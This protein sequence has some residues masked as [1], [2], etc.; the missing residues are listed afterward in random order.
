[1]LL[2]LWLSFVRSMHLN[3][4]QVYK[5]I[6][7]DL[8]S[9]SESF[10]YIHT[11]SKEATELIVLV[12]C[13]SDVS[14]PH[15]MIG[16][17]SEV[18][19]KNCLK[20]DK[21][22]NHA[23]IRLSTSDLEVNQTYHLK[24]TCEIFCSY[25]IHLSLVQPI[26]LSNSVPILA[27]VEAEKSLIFAF[28]LTESSVDAFISARFSGDLEMLIYSNS[29]E[30]SALP[31]TSNRIDDLEFYQNDIS[32]VSKYI[33][34]LKGKKASRFTLLAKDNDTKSVSLIP[35]MVYTDTILRSGYSNFYVSIHSYVSKI[36]ISLTVFNGDADLYLS[37]STQPTNTSYDIISQSIGNDYIKLDRPS[38]AHYDFS[39]GRVYISVHGYTD[40][41]FSIVC[42][43][44]QTSSVPLFDGIPQQATILNSELLNFNY[45]VSSSTVDLS[46]YL[47]T[48]SG[49]ADIYVKFCYDRCHISIEDLELDSVFKSI[50]SSSLQLIDLK[51]EPEEICISTKMCNLAVAVFAETRSYFSLTAATLVSQIK[52]QQGLSFIMSSP[53]AGVRVYEY[54]VTNPS[55][56]EVDF[57]LSPIL[58]DPDICVRSQGYEEENCEMRSDK[59][60][61]EIDQVVFVKGEEKETLESL[62]LISVTC[63]SGCY[64]SIIARE[65]AVGK[66]NTLHLI[67]GHPQKDTLYNVTDKDYRLY[68]FCVDSVKSDLKIVLT[69]ITGKF[70][71]FVSNNPDNVDWKNEKFDY[72]WKATENDEN[73]EVLIIRKDDANYLADSNYL[74]LVQANK[75]TSDNSAT[76]SIQFARSDDIMMLTADANT[77]GQVQENSYAYYSFP[78]HYSHMDLK[79]SLMVSTGD[80]DLYISFDY[81]NSRPTKSLYSIR[82]SHFG[83]E[84]LTLLWDDEISKYCPDINKE[85]T[86][87][88]SHGCFI[89]I[90]VYSQY[91]SAFTLRVSPLSEVPKY[92]N[93]GGFVHS[94]LSSDE[95]DFYYLFIDVVDELIIILQ[96]A[97]GE[98]D[99]LVSLMEKKSAPDDIQEWERPTEDFAMIKV[100]NLLTEEVK[101]TS[102]QLQ[103]YCSQTCI[104]LISVKCASS[105]CVFLLENPEENLIKL[106]EGQAKYG[107]AGKETQFYSYVC[108]KEREEI[109]IILT[110]IENCNPSLYVAKGKNRRPGPED[111]D[112]SSE[113]S[114][115]DSV[116][117]TSNDS[118]FDRASMIGTYVIGVQ[119][120]SDLCSYTLTVT[121]HEYPVVILNPGLPQQGTSGGGL[122]S[123]YAL[124][125]SIAQKIKISVT[126][127]TGS[128]FIV[129]SI[130]K[131]TEDELYA[132]LPTYTY[133][134]WNSKFEED[135]YSITITSSDKD[136]C[137][138]CYYLIGIASDDY[139]SFTVIGNEEL[140]MKLLQNGVPY[141]SELEPGN[142][143]LFSFSVNV[144]K[145]FRVILA[146]YSGE[147]NFEVSLTR[148]MNEISWVPAV[149]LRTKSLEVLP[150]DDKFKI[151]TYYLRVT[152]SSKNALYSLVWY[153]QGAYISLI[154]GWSMIYSI[155]ATQKDPIKF[156]FDQTGSVFCSVESLFHQSNPSVSAYLNPK[157]STNKKAIGTFSSLNYTGNHLSLDFIVPS[158]DSLTLL[159]NDAEITFRES[160]EFSLYCT[161]SFH[162]AVLTPGKQSIG[163]LSSSIPALRYE[164]TLSKSQN[165]NIYVIPCE[166]SIRLQAST[167]WTII[168]GDQ[169]I[170]TAIKLTD[171][172]IVAQVM[173]V[174]GKVYLSVLRSPSASTATFKIY[175]DDKKLPRLYAGNQGFIS[176]A[177]NS[178][179]VKLEWSGVEYANGSIYDGQV[180]YYLFYTEDSTVMLQST[181]QAQYAA[182][183]SM[184]SWIGNTRDLKTEIVLKREGFVTIVAH[185]EQEGV[186]PLRDLIYDKIKITGTAERAKAGKLIFFLSLI[187]L[188]LFAGLGI[189]FWKFRK[190]KEE[191]KNF[192]DHGKKIALEENATG[193]VTINDV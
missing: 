186:S 44:D 155:K 117:I 78:V 26:S 13:I 70:S 106:N 43:L 63:F 146:E 156:K 24:V 168:K 116:K 30:N 133:F 184:G 169:H 162:P 4:G 187:V 2:Y 192:E 111:F 115:G 9:T 37:F 64:Y 161:A 147:V 66:N 87:G 134:K 73:S 119:S 183:H 20:Y 129:V 141:K 75:F 45:E 31:I 11:D 61:V 160:S 165:L 42:R 25:S 83:S 59:S 53:I 34:V 99:L 58:G 32:G 185:V 71:M 14:D 139:T 150:E 176:W 132:E 180:T 154:D 130:H 28:E 101:M 56:F 170:L 51:Y 100:K 1:M 68:Y 151:G 47:T 172:A 74:I 16:L 173:D 107:M 182:S 125:N 153:S 48:F 22:R 190:A 105:S 50:G 35:S 143:D 55:V 3:D 5:A 82:S 163:H 145:G 127:N 121:N 140:N 89:Y 95:Y 131:D 40:T 62:Y 80:P 88:N 191:M 18:S 38:F 152:T 112:W 189:Y 104:V 144:K 79:I 6:L 188:V 181:C 178:E 120:E 67:P 23:L 86:H 174:E 92:I 171:G 135:K 142:W 123:Y 109:L 12:S 158:T 65:K 57:T 138:F 7:S 96:N 159:I 85:Y 54:S 166:G 114:G 108:D 10:K 81:L 19:K 193:N 103:E 39:S 148:D 15:L 17:S 69:G 77:F 8:T 33:I 128:P 49:D 27:S 72:H 46:I 167:N 149:G 126:P 118:K 76:Y 122:I 137:T 113:S 110:P 124:Y 98:S 21:S 52:L 90:G 84:T 91:S 93:R 102:A 136:F 60:G 157:K 177:Y 175:A 29:L 97:R 164:F 94:S 179:K 36:E 41:S